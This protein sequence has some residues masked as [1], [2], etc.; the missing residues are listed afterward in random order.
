METSTT[1]EMVLTRVFE[2][3]VEA[4]WA[5]WTQSDLVKR[6]WGPQ[7]FTAPV[8]EM[9]VR[10]GGTSLVCMR[11]PAEFGGQDFYNT[12]TYRA[13]VPRE[14]LEFVHAF[15]DA[16]RNPLD[17]TDIGLPSGIPREVPHVVTFI[18]LDSGHTE[19]TV[20]ESGY[21]SADVVEVSRSGMA[22]CLDKMAAV[23]ERAGESS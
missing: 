22:E 21:L 15:T 7:G 12:W 14:R 9:D 1:H 6:W 19:L 17:P 16:D 20:R 5:A 8:A 11:A 23:V 3:P 18:A 10:D 2:A 13:V 4:V